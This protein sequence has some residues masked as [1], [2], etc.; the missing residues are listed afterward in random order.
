MKQET[1]QNVAGLADDRLGALLIRAEKISPTE[2]EQALRIQRQ[3]GGRIGEV[4]INQGACS[5]DDVSEQLSQQL[6]LPL[7]RDWPDNPSDTSQ[8]E[9]YGLSADWWIKQQSFPLGEREGSLWVATHDVLDTFIVNTV[10][11]ISGRK[12]KPVV[13]GSHELRQ[14]LALLEESDAGNAIADDTL[15]QDLATG[16]PIIKFVNDTIQRALDAH[17]S[18]IHFESYRGIFRIRFRVDGVLHEVDRPN[19]GMQ[20]A[21]ISRL[22]LMAS[23]DISE[24]RL[25]QDGRIRI[26]VGGTELDIRVATSPGVAGES[27]ILRLLISEGG[28]ETIADL[29]MHQD[30]Q[31]MVLKLL[32]HTNGILLVTGPTGSGKST[33]LYA[34]LREL[35]G[36]ERKII[37]VEDPVEYQTSGISQIPVNAEIGLS[38]ASVLRSVL[39]QDPDIIMVGEI[40]DRETAEIAVQAAL[41]GHLVLSTLHTNDAPSAFVRLID[42]GI[43]P[44]LL[45]SSIVGVLG[46]RL[47][48]S[49][50]PKCAVTDVEAQAQA[51]AMGWLDVKQQ[52]PELVQQ[53][54]FVKGPG[55]SHCL[56]SGY[57]G[58]R[59]IFEMLEVGPELQH[60]LSAEPERLVRYFSKQKMRT[61]KQDGLLAAS[62]GLTTVAEVLRVTG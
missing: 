39:R 18:D 47:V 21:I 34:F 28:V 29:G 59:S 56:G 55:C 32:S 45:A 15:L 48:R 23:L 30:H 14:L 16:A 43:E 4:L 13:T 50:C 27:V 6:S 41:T 24:K 36:D 26:K 2:L 22:K 58:R 35:M 52:W 44:Y 38:F 40:R 57:R 19:L 37:T 9:L 54:H 7:L 3:Y 12:V 46:Q 11:Q 17:A 25:P 60:V 5:E 33:S 31:A 10:G 1:R 49:V 8:I 61:L 62:E 51:A 53:E 42:M 20:P